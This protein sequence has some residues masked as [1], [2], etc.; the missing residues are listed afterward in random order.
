MKRTILLSAVFLFVSLWLVSASDPGTGD[1]PMWGG[2]P[3]RNMV[4]PMKGLP[5]SWDIKTKKNV[6]WVAQ[7][8][9]RAMATR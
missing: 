1:W 6:K 8:V 7:L 9:R 2:S 4:S 5:T 3:E